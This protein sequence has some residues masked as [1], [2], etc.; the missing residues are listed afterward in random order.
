MLILERLSN[1]IILYHGSYTEVS[2]I[3]LSMCRQGLDFGRGFYLTSSEEQAVNFVKNS[4]SK[5]I[6][7]GRVP[8]D[9]VLTDGI[10]S[11]FRYKKLPN[12]IE[13]YF[14][15][16]D[17]EWL[18]FVI[19]NRNRAFF[20][21]FV[22][23]ISSADIIGGKI[24]NDRT[25]QTLDAYMAGAYGIPGSKEADEMAIKTLLPNRLK[26]QFCFKTEKAIASLEFI[27]G[28]KYAEYF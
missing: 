12:I 20:Q 21:D 27:K 1:D 4:V 15:E 25:V 5:A 24:A 2:S 11:V 14:D 7:L 22:N 19:G 18:H 6:K 3:D 17:I 8:A 13:H 23:K 28:I 16:A 10:V 9:F 26:D